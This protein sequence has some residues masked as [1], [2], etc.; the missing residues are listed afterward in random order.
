MVISFFIKGGKIDCN[1][2]RGL[3]SLDVCKVMEPLIERGLKVVEELQGSN[4]KV[5]EKKNNGS[6]YHYE[7][8]DNNTCK[9]KIIAMFCSLIS[10]K[11]MIQ[12]CE[13]GCCN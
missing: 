2:Y 12:S 7:R 11:Y 13:L 5:S 3:S 8:R 1:N 10:E 6:G 9:Y 4:R